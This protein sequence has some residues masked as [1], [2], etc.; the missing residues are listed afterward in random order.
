MTDFTPA[1]LE[2]LGRGLETVAAGAAELAVDSRDR[3]SKEL[4]SPVF[5]DREPKLPI[6][7]ILDEYLTK[8]LASLG[9]PVLSEESWTPDAG[10]PDTAFLVVD[11]LDG[12]LNFGRGS[13]PSAISLALWDNGPILGVVVRLDTRDTFVGGPSLG[14]RRNGD[15]IKVSAVAQSSLATLATGFPSAFDFHNLPLGAEVMT[16]FA[17]FGKIR[18]LGSAAVSLCLVAQGSI[19]VYEEH[20]IQVWD[21]AA[22]LAIVEGAGGAT[23]WSEP[24]SR[25]MHVRASNGLIAHETA[26]GGSQ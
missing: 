6:D 13:G 21:V 9:L 15:K 10:L 14:S 7:T 16:A 20:D 17:N 19:D 4:L 8:N 23:S 24:P 25:P 3:F 11:P 12:S 2:H 22:G 26:L 5:L 1:D 18:M